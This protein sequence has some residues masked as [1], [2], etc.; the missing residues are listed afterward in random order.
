M[1]VPIAPGVSPFR[2][3]AS[4]RP[5]PTA[6]RTATPR[7]TATPADTADLVGSVLAKIREHK[8]E[9]N[10]LIFF[11]SDNGGP[12]KELTSRNDPFSGGK[13]SLREGGVR[14]PFIARWPGQIPTASTSAQTI[15]LTDLL[16]TIAS[17]VGTKLSDNAS[18]DSFDILP[19]LREGAA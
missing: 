3:S 13:G 17:I 8:L 1:A 15:C 12:T 18:E 9:E 14:V 19:A 16:A 10:T 4:P 2:A 6:S 7:D 5:A 11:F